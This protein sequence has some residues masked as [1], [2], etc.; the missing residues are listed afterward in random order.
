MCF[1]PANMLR[2]ETSR[3]GSCK[4]SL[5]VQVDVMYYVL[6]YKNVYKTPICLPPLSSATS[7]LQNKG[8]YSWRGSH[9]LMFCLC[10]LIHIECAVSQALVTWFSW[11]LPW[12]DG[13]FV[14]PEGTLHPAAHTATQ[15]W[16]ML[17]CSSHRGQEHCVC[18]VCHTYRLCA[19]LSQEMSLPRN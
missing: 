5:V 15:N 11:Q 6:S 1:R 12:I 8:G 9:T 2:I 14:H 3:R 19:E 16:V 17:S 4:C 7:R 10:A 18:S 13:L